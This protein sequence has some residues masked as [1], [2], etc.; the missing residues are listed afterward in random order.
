MTLLRF[1][2]IYYAINGQLDSAEYYFR[3]VGDH[4]IPN[5]ILRGKALFNLS[6]I[7]K[8]RGQFEQAL[9]FLGQAL[10]IYEEVGD[11]RLVAEVSRRN[12]FSQQDSGISGYFTGLSAPC[13]SNSGE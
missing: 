11:K 3:Y 4:A 1:Y 8:N 13:Y 9:E 6:V 7:H 10:K 12:G 2:G 5:S